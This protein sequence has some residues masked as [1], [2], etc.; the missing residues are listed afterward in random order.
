MDCKLGPSGGPAPLLWP[1][2]TVVGIQNYGVGARSTLLFMPSSTLQIL[3]S[4]G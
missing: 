2:M 3:V 4:K 1:S